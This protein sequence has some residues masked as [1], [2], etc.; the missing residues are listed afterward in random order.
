MEKYLF[1]KGKHMN[2]RVG[3]RFLA[4]F[5]LGAFV[6][7]V[8]AATTPTFEI[9]TWANFCQGAISHTFDDYAM[10][11]PPK[12]VLGSIVNG[13]ARAAF[14]A[15][16]FHPTIFVVTNTCNADNWKSL[17]S[18][19]A[20]GYEIGSHSVTHAA[21]A[22]ELGP[23]QDTIKKHVPGEMCV[24]FAYPNGT[25]VSGVLNRY[26]AARNIQGRTNPKTPPDFSQINTQGFGS[27]SGNYP[28]DAASMNKL[29]DD[30]AAGNMWATSMNHG[31]T[32]DKHDWAVTNLDEMVK[33][34]D[35]LDKNRDKIWCETFGNVARYIKE[36]NAA[37]ITVKSSSSSS[38]TITVTDNLADSIFNYPLSIRCEM[39]S[40]WTTAMVK[41][42]SKTMVDTIVTVSSKKYIMFKAVPN[43]GDVVVSTATRTM[44]RYFGFSNETASPVKRLHSALIID[45]NR[46]EGSSLSVTLFNLQGKELARYSLEGSQPHIL[47]IGKMKGSALIAK[48]AGGGKM[49]VGTFLPEI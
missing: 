8:S 42:G 6:I 45:P 44:E 16:G 9:G 14:D 29:A 43:A 12:V 39:P 17:Q 34:L 40:G 38:Y 47:Q 25:A 21:N 36:R 32:P 3:F 13:Q 1:V 2:F 15:K 30:A 26:I 18:A 7:A 41:Q 23:S 24:S 11:S 4:A 19:F 46:F 33:H 49:Y 35:Y 20:Q 28:N 5:I 37:K 22:S 31:I 48:V 27:G 10:N